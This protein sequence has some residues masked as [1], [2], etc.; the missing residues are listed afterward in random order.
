M[1]KP[2][3]KKPQKLKNQIYRYATIKIDLEREV[4]KIANLKKGRKF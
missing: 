1:T 2:K 3:Q 4:E